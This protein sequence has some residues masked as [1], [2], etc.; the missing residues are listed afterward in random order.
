M[1]IA[2]VDRKGR[3]MDQVINCTQDQRNIIL[4]VS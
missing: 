2:A 4:A 3:E 1:T